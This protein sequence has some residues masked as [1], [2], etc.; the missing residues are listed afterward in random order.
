MK[1]LIIDERMREVEKQCLKELGYEIIELKHSSNVYEEIS[2][3]T[4]IFTCKID[5]KL[6]VEKSQ[7]QFIKEKIKISK[8][9]FSELKANYPEDIKYNVCVFGNFAVHNFKYTDKNILEELQQKEYKLINVNQGYSNCSIA[10]IDDNSVITSD[11]GIYNSLKNENIDVLFLENDLDI[12]LLKK[13]EY[14]DKKGFI[15][16]AISRIGNNIFVSGDLNKIDKDK[17]IR[18]FINKRNL[19]IIEFPSLDV[20]DYGGIVEIT[21]KLKLNLKI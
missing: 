13:D 15:G 14:S 16:G 4:D 12:K 2:S 3:H 9:G 6:F 1:F 17:K 8:K 7:Y 10:V 19:N 18:E 20:I 21:N 11:Q 5:N